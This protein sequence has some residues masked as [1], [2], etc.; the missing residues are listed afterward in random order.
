MGWK[1]GTRRA[2]A[3][4]G[5]KAGVLDKRSGSA[6]ARGGPRCIA[7]VRLRVAAR[8]RK[9]RA[10]HDGPD[11]RRRRQ[12]CHPEPR[13][14]R[15][16]QAHGHRRRHVVG[17]REFHDAHPV[18]PL[19]DPSTARERRGVEASPIRDRRT[20]GRDAADRRARRR[21][22]DKGPSA[23]GNRC[24]R[25]RFRRMAPSRRLAAPL[26]RIGP[27]AL[28]RIAK[29]HVG[30][31]MHLSIRP[32]VD[33][34]LRAVRRSIS[35]MARSP[36]PST[37]AVAVLIR[38]ASI[39]ID[40]A[41]LVLHSGGQYT[42]SALASIAPIRV[43]AAFFERCIA[44]TIY[45]SMKRRRSNQC[46]RSIITIHRVCPNIF[47]ECISVNINCVILYIIRVFAEARHDRWRCPHWITAPPL[48]GSA[49]S[50]A[51][52]VRPVRMQV[53][54]ISR[55]RVATGLVSPRI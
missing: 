31:V 17:D 25:G 7:G 33:G 20:E 21:L 16:T 48:R 30:H 34:F 15:R 22:R 42:T 32:A 23:S 27:I 44:G 50:P 5:A 2:R 43:A 11:A 55:Q 6:T 37:N 46:R 53:V 3:V 38:L 36:P 24:S 41:R 14:A 40:D 45:R 47:R 39:N 13:A 4:P 54:G 8:R 1:L 9:K 12:G 19:R 28:A 29:R 52:F 35:R 51:V 10:A 49:P 18:A 26:R